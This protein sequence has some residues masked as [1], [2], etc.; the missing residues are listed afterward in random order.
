MII[1]DEILWATGI[2]HRM[3]HWSFKTFPVTELNRDARDRAEEWADSWRTPGLCLYGVAGA[4]KTGLAV[5]IIRHRISQD[6]SQDLQWKILS[7][8]DVYAAVAQGRLPHQQ[9]APIWFQR[10]LRL[11]DRIY[12]TQ[13]SVSQESASMLM[14]EIDK[15]DT[16]VLDDV[17]TGALTPWKEEILLR[18]VERVEQHQSTV[19]TMN[20]HPLELALIMGE[21][22]AD[23]LAD[24]EVFTH[25]WVRGPTLRRH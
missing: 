13:A 5:S 17:D 24:E 12:Q 10:W 15:I 11:A 4:G 3:R 6:A 20:H 7:H 2:P 18:I 22:L 23:R 25:I 14:A 16:L 9:F 8:P 1:T 19:F 21:R